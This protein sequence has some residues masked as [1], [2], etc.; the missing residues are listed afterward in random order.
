MLLA[1]LPTALHRPED[2]TGV[3]EEQ[4][5]R[6]QTARPVYDADSLDPGVDRR[7]VLG[8]RPS[9]RDVRRPD[10]AA[11]WETW[12]TERSGRRR[13]MTAASNCPMAAPSGIGT[14]LPIC[15]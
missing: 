6:K 10:G 8:A 12:R 5:L 11:S 4:D 15:L 2:P 7:P 13:Q 14:A 3:L 1:R 9:G